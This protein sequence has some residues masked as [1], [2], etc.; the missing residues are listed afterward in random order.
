[1]IACRSTSAHAGHL[2]EG[3]EECRAFSDYRP[4]VQLRALCPL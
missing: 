3:L 1:M 4:E 2:I